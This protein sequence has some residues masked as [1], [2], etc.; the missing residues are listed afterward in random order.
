MKTIAIASGV[1]ALTF[2]VIGFQIGAFGGRHK[3]SDDTSAA[4]KEAP[5]ITATFPEDLAPSAQAKPVPAA[6]AYKPGPDPHPIAFLRVN[7][8]LHPWQESLRED[9]K[10]E[11]VGMT[12]LAVVVGTQTR[13][14]V[15]YHDKWDKLNAPPI[16]R[17]QYDLEISVIE[18][19]T[20]R[21]LANRTFRNV[22]R[23]ID[24]VEA[25]ETTSIGRAVSAAQVF[26]WVARTS[27][28]G[29]PEAHDPTP[30]TAQ[31]D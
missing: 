19:K 12:E 20:G 10:A 13:A 5:K 7:G 24:H 2:V 25:W 11:S 21:I 3:S 17:Y 6:A 18:A 30:I 14:K 4:E 9:W 1:C 15:S 26:N 27:R 23:P 16:T 8:T 22:P 28:T 29:F 31:V